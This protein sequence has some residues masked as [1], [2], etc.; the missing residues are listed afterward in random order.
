MQ[1]LF[2]FFFAEEDLDLR[3]LAVPNKRQSSDILE[4]ANLKKTKAEKFDA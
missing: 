2:N 3:V 4:S 1:V